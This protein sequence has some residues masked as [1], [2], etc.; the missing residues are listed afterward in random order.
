MYLAD[1]RAGGL[2]TGIKDKRPAMLCGHSLSDESAWGEPR[3]RARTLEGLW[4]L[5]WILQDLDLPR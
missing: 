1:F 2:A 4:L 3:R 5:W